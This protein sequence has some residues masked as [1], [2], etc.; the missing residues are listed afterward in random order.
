MSEP[1]SPLVYKLTTVDEWSMAIVTGIFAGSDD[2]ERDG[3]IHLSAA[4]QLGETAKKYFSG[5][6]DLCLIAFEAAELGQSLVWEPSRGGQ[7]FPHYYGPLPALSALWVR[8]VPLDPQGVP[9]VGD[10]EA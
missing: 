10:V 1:Q 8:P 4:G 6:E 7:L 5:C 3:Y 2:D 9:I